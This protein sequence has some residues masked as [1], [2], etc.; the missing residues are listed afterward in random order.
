MKI[1]VYYHDDV[2]VNKGSASEFVRT[3]CEELSHH[4]IVALFAYGDTNE[5]R[6][7]RMN[8]YAY[9]VI[10]RNKFQRFLSKGQLSKKVINAAI[11]HLPLLYLQSKIFGPD[12]VI[13]VDP[14]AGLSTMAL[15]KRDG[16]PVVYRPNDSLSLLAKQLK[17]TGNLSVAILVTLYAAVAANLIASKADL[18]LPSSNL[19]KEYKNSKV[20]SLVLPY[21][22][23]RVQSRNLQANSQSEVRRSLGLPSDKKIL[24]FLG[25]GDWEPNRRAIDYI[26][27]TLA[28]QFMDSI[29]DVLFLI[30]GQHTEAYRSAGNPTNVI[31]V[32]G[33]R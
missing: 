20:Q 14:F 16:V 3:L 24:L 30:V 21:C 1:A 17:Q 6:I 18:I 22:P 33:G 28:P 31:I 32:G 13:C 29:P 9:H 23:P 5:S 2:I 4:F 15:A 11:A 27:R 8:G 12:V 19:V 7:V 10:K 26:I 25:T